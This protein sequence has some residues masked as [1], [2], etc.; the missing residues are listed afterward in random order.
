MRILHTIPSLN[1]RDGG[2]P[3]ALKHM[4]R[5]LNEIGIETEIATTTH[6][7]ELPAVSS[8][9]ELIIHEGVPVR[10]F[11]QVAWLRKYGF[12]TACR[13]WLKQ[14]A[15][16]YDIIHTH[17]VLSPFSSLVMSCAQQQGVP[18]LIRPLGVL[19]PWSLTQA[20]WKKRLFIRFIDR[21]NLAQA[22]VIHC[23]S[24]KEAQDVETLQ[25]GPETCVIPHGVT[26]PTKIAR[27]K[28][29]LRAKVG[30]R[31]S[32]RLIVFIGRLHPKKGLDLLLKALGKCGRTDFK[33]VL[34]GEG[35]STFV[36]SLKQLAATLNLSDQLH[37][38]GF[39]SGDAKDVLLQGADLFALTSHHEN[40]A[41]AA[42]EAL[43]AGTPV[44]L[45][46]NVDLAPV[47]VSNKMGWVSTL[48]LESISSCLNEFFRVGIP[49]TD[50]PARAGNLVEQQYSWTRQ[51]RRLE[52]LY[53]SILST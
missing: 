13:R 50:F 40:F 34:A 24:E 52:S 29:K 32:D 1:A 19:S 41:L 26:V 37:L 11:P 8:A 30:A 51:A 42:L 35:D 25:L 6:G 48:E 17:A 12:S 31:P 28:D 16:N 21:T 14:N 39:V 9:G 49:D 15:R 10:F 7:L 38:I 33:L 45:S 23:T 18:Y 47:V 3:E 5:A 46:E 20:R 27:A 43:A 36:D 4:V 53:R 22:E 2:P 44:L